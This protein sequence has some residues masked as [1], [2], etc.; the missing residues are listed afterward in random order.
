MKEKTV[1]QKL[2]VTFEV[3]VDGS[4]FTF[5]SPYG[6]NFGS[7]YDAAR[8]FMK[9]IVELSNEVVEKTKRPEAKIEKVAK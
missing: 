4:V 1:D 3:E 5:S 9:K 8:E 7:Q 6:A 2:V